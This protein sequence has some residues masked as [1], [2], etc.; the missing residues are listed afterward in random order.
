MYLLLTIIE[1]LRALKQYI[2]P[3]QIILWAGE[4][5]LP[6][7]FLIIFAETGLMIGFFLP[8]DSLLFLAGLFCATGII[9]A[10]IFTMIAA[11]VAAAILGDQVGYLIGKKVGKA[12]FTRE[13]SFLFK[14]KYVAQTRAFYD[15]HGAKTIIIGRFVPI[16]RTFAPVVAG[17][18]EIDYKKFVVYNVTGGFLWIVSMSLLGYLPVYFL[19]PEFAKL[20]IR[21]YISFITMGIIILSVI[22]IFTTWLQ[23]RKNKSQ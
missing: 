7:L 12:L 17:V 2:D 3:E 18:T 8:G 19:G 23:E 5:A 6:V 21:P 4:F 15:R 13:E 22:P 16:V 1:Q 20:Y 11:L 10:N 9:P 14:P